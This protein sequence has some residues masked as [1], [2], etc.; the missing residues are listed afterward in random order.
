MKRPVEFSQDVADRICDAVANGKSLV[1]V[2]AEDWAPHR[3]TVFRWKAA[4]EE[5]SKQLEL[6][7]AERADF[8][9]D[10]IHNIADWCVEDSEA[11]AKAR[12]R[13]EARKWTLAR[14]APK[15][16][17]DKLQHTGDGGGDIV[18]RWATEVE[19]GE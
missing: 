16:Y 11:I 14:M 6:A 5:F 3:R 13:I 7:T 10:E 4:N 19:A 9:F 17:G 15:K 8:Y 12:L 18:V 1:Q 2:C